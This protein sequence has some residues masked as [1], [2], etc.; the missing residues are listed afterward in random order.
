MSR[1]YTCGTQYNVDSVNDEERVSEQ[2][3][4]Q[5]LVEL[6]L[7][8]T[9]ALVRLDAPGR[10]CGIAIRSGKDVRLITARHVIGKGEWAVEAASSRPHVTEAEL[11]FAPFGARTTLLVGVAPDLL[12]LK[13]ST[14]DIAWSLPLRG[15]SSEVEERWH[16]P[17]Y[18][19]PLTETFAE[20]EAYVVA[21]AVHDEHHVNAQAVRREVVYEAY[22]E[23]VGIADGHSKLKLARPHRGD[24][25]FFGVSGAPI[26]DAVGK[27][28]GVLV[29]GA[30]SENVLL[31]ASLAQFMAEMD[32]S[33]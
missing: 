1:S 4:L 18:E 12:A 29:G 21:A 19:G 33:S 24:E 13:R 17:I 31:A 8:N 2:A 27:V 3:V 15:V 6:C 16:L 28:V 20:D 32:E 23:F 22:L 26:M 11:R 9:L 7:A 25:G 10:G 30:A 5:A 14:Q